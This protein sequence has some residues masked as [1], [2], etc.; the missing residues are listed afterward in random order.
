MSCKRRFTTYERAENI[1]LT[2]VR[3]DGT[4][5][6]FDRSALK[7]SL[8]EACKGR[9]G[10]LHQLDRM[11]AL[12]EQDFPKPADR[13]LTSEEICRSVL[14]QLRNI[15]SVAYLRFAAAHLDLKEVREF[16][17]LV[18]DLL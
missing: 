18:D 10:A 16:A 7:A 13:E 15:D 14:E 12:V 17:S 4:R 1:P 8:L 3:R 5:E 11:A 9:P 2:V 6:P